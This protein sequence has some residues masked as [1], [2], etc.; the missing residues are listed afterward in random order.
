MEFS[1][2]KCKVIKQWLKSIEESKLA[3]MRVQLS[4]YSL[5]VAF[6][7]QKTA[8]LIPSFVWWG[9]QIL[10]DLKLL[11]MLCLPF[12][13]YRMLEAETCFFHSPY[14]PCLALWMSRD[15]IHPVSQSNLQTEDTQQWNEH[16]YWYFAA[17]GIGKKHELGTER[18]INLGEN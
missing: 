7:K 6:S 8:W 14:T 10:S 17:E 5:L 9:S 15:G 13:N 18:L 3:I 2:S 11:L 12:S 16:N 4:N 1:T